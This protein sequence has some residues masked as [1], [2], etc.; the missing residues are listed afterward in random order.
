MFS[1]FIA[2][3]AACAIA[4]SAAVDSSFNNV[5]ITHETN[6]D[7]EF[8]ASQFPTEIRAT[9]KKRKHKAQKE[10]LK[11]QKA[12]AKANKVAARA[13]QASLKE[14]GL[15]NVAANKAAK[16][17]SREMHAVTKKEDYLNFL[18]TKMGLKDTTAW[19]MGHKRCYTSESGK[20]SVSPLSFN[21]L[22]G[23]SVQTNLM[24]QVDSAAAP[25]LLNPGQFFL[26]V[27]GGKKFVEVHKIEV[28][29]SNADEFSFETASDNWQDW[30][31]A[32]LNVAES[33]YGQ[34]A[35]A[36]AVKIESNL[37]FAERSMADKLFY[38]YC[39]SGD[40]SLC[41]S[42]P[43]GEYGWCNSVDDSSFSCT[44]KGDWFGDACTEHACM[45][46]ETDP[47]GMWGTCAVNATSTQ[48]HVC[49]CQDGYWGA[50][51][52]V[53]ACDEYA[54]NNGG[55]CAV[56]EDGSAMCTCTADWY[57]DNCDETDCVA[58]VEGVCVNAAT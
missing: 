13:E 23:G 38:F 47:C 15:A 39:G 52:E 37:S 35:A 55:S 6:C 29:G 10:Y 34:I 27:K 44:C 19:G 50:Q 1:K 56:Q 45:N 58:F 20:A 43:C 53:S 36:L 41:S 57:G 26:V 12:L 5:V 17:E 31:G 32:K 25:G 28:L 40:T 14:T 54:C 21:D 22:G 18:L 16:L 46:F 30:D 42:K 9:C 2:A 48:E 8:P 49:D 7:A 4:S 24:I 33:M 3:S 11:A 51:C